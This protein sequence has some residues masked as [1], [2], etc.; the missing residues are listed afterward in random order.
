MLAPVGAA[1]AAWLI[2]GALAEIAARVRLFE[3]APRESLR[4]ARNLPRADW[5]KALAHAGLGVTIFGI[6]AIT[7]WSI[8]DIRVARPGESFRVGAYEL[9]LDAVE[10]TRGPNYDADTATVAVLR[11]GGPVATLHPEKRLYPVQGMATTEA[12]IDRGATRDLYVALGDPQEGGWALR[13][14]IKPFSNWIWLGAMIM[15]AGGVVSLT[16]RRYR[17]GAPAR[18]AAPAALPAE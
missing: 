15:A 2:L 7:A 18:R 9:R 12:A 1:L 14:Y 10:R 5:G 13:T 16:D 6:T 4:R 8:E 11:D 17:V 3:A